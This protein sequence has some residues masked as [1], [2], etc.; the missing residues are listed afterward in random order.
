MTCRKKHEM[1]IRIVRV[2]IFLENDYSMCFLRGKE[3]IGLTG[4]HFKALIY[5]SDLQCKNI[6]L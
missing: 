2:K 4:R 1:E 5:I 6:I 3:E